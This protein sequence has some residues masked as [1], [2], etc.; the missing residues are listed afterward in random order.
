M[1]KILCALLVCVMCATTVF[2]FAGCGCSDNASESKVE[3]GYVV[4]PTEPDMK[5]SNFGYYIIDSERLMVSAYYGSSM[6]IVIP[7]TYNNYKVTVIGPSLF[8]GSDITSVTMPDSITEIR[9]YAF[10]S[11]HKLTSVKLSNN[12]KVFGN[13]VF[14]NTSELKSIEIPASVEDLGTRTFSACGLESVTIPKSDT[15]TTIGEFV[16]FQCQKLKEV[17]LPVTVTNISDNAFSECPNKI[18]IKAPESSY[19]QSYAKKNNFE[20]EAAN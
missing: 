11:C 1:K 16:F 18:T 8:N 12:I 20:F 10:S 3:P 7:E 13:G 6:D 5:D 15:L 4:E 9:D 14:F 19:A 17:N 2:A